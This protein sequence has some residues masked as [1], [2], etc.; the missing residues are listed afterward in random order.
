METCDKSPRYY[1]SLAIKCRTSVVL[2]GD[3]AVNDRSFRLGLRRVY[4][5]IRLIDRRRNCVHRWRLLFAAS[6]L[7]LRSC[8]SMQRHAL[9]W[10]NALRVEAVRGMNSK[11]W[12]S[13]KVFATDKPRQII[14]YWSTLCPAS[15]TSMPFSFIRKTQ[16]DVRAIHYCIYSA[17]MVHFVLTV[18]YVILECCIC[19]ISL[20]VKASAGELGGRGVARNLISV[21]INGSRRQNYHIKKIKVD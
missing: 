17:V 12:P 1:G 14:E 15:R 8:V 9:L 2:L 16:T 18:A 19:C 3:C 10:D 11:R 20:T 4:L 7:A 21:G 5:F 6:R 13:K